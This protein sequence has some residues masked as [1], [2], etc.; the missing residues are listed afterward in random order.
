M[1]LLELKGLTKRFGGL[2][3][4]K[5]L[6]LSIERGEI[7]GLIGPNGAGKTTVFNII[8]GSFSPSEG[9]VIFKGK[10]ITGQKPHLIVKQ[11]LAR[12]FQ[13]TLLFGEM[14]VLENILIPLYSISNT[15]FLSPFFKPKLLKKEKEKLTDKAKEISDFMGLSSMNDQ[16]AK[17]LPHGFQRMLGVGIAFATNPEMILLDEP[18][19]GMNI[20][21][22]NQM[23]DKIKEIRERGITVLVVE[24]DMRL[25]MNICDRL[26]VLNF[27]SKI[28]EG[29]PSEIRK[30]K[31]VIDIYL[32][33]E[34][35]SQ[36]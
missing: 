24:H 22:T 32:G 33:S 25:I 35:A 23:M 31:E 4:V 29:P 21:E 6:D 1:P 19:A 36:C 34:Y 2:V 11:G 10:E 5:N 28:A 30:S 3:A 17:N 13:R 27:G 18:V 14:T 20:E 8:M 16:L 26:C 12:S 7:F 9:K 15:G